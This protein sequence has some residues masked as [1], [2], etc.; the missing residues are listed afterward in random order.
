MRA[1]FDWY[2]DVRLVA[3]EEL[4]R[5]CKWLRRHLLFKMVSYTSPRKAD[6]KHKNWGWS[7]KVV[8]VAIGYWDDYF[9]E[10]TVDWG[11]AFRLH[12]DGFFEWPAGPWGAKGRLELSDYESNR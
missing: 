5:K 4:L 7:G 8:E 6:G 10:I 12:D 3:S 2:V 1:K 11:H 9:V